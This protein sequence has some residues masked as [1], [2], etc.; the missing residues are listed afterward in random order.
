MPRQT[1]PKPDSPQICVR[2][3]THFIWNSLKRQGHYITRTNSKDYFLCEE[4]DKEWAKNDEKTNIRVDFYNKKISKEKFHNEF[5][6]IFFK[7]LEKQ[8]VV[9][10]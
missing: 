2:C 6:R 9:F 8:K 5:L 7:F 3:G 1:K 4:C 10:D